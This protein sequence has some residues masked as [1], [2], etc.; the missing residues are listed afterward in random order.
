MDKETILAAIDGDPVAADFAAQQ[1]DPACADRLPAIWPAVRRSVPADEVMSVAVHR[2]RWGAIALACTEIGF[3]FATRATA[4]TL[5]DWIA[6][7]K[8]ID[9]TLAEV[10]GMIATLK[11]AGLVNDLDV[12][13]IN[14]LSWAR[15]TIAPIDVSIAMT[16]RRQGAT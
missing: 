16:E 1:N 3:D 10:Q 8:S 11:A 7:G 2:G 5:V 4:K 6:A 13:A 12:E 15:I 9:V 14:A